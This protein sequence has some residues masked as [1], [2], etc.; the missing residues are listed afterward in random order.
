M[1]SAEHAIA[2]R[3]QVN[4]LV[5]KMCV[6]TILLSN[7]PPQKKNR[8]YSYIDAKTQWTHSLA[9]DPINLT[10]IY[11][12]STIAEYLS[13]NYSHACHAQHIKIDKREVALSCTVLIAQKWRVSLAARALIESFST[14]SLLGSMVATSLVISSLIDNEHW[15]DC[16]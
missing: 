5:F 1:S 16:S 2:F 15:W 14:S 9:Q 4:Y 3:Y 12:W 10:D 13:A 8:K 7:T 11:I 6:L